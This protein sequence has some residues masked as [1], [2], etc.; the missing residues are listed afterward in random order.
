MMR[1]LPTALSF[2]LVS[3]TPGTWSQSTKRL[4]NLVHVGL[5]RCP[6]SQGCCLL[7]FQKTSN[8][9]NKARGYQMFVT[10]S[11]SGPQSRYCRK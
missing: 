6:K 9:C 4:Y 11:T 8:F 7:L 1:L 5:E 2:S 3:E 10:S